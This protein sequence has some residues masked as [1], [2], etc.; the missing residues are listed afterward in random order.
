M[1]VI[2]LLLL[3]IAVLV[4]GITLSNI[5]EPLVAS[6]WIS[7]LVFHVLMIIVYPVNYLLFKAYHSLTDSR[8]EFESLAQIVVSALLFVIHLAISLYTLGINVNVGL[9]IGVLL[10]ALMII[11]G[12]ALPKTKPNVLFG[13]RTIWALKD[14]EV[15]RLTNKFAGKL[16][17]YFGVVL[18]VCTLILANSFFLMITALLFI[19]I[20]V[21]IIIEVFSFKTYKNLHSK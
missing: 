3:I 15:W 5:G 10:G 14:D 21:T 17:V 13:A 20:S 6:M 16:F 7:L 9:V 12:Y 1:R 8:F 19:L 18:I 2:P 4:S 11:A